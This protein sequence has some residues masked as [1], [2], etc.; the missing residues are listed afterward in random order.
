[1]RFALLMSAL[2]LAG[3]LTGALILSLGGLNIAWS[4]TKA[5][6][7]TS[8]TQDRL[9]AAASDTINFL[10]TNGNYAQTR[11]FPGA[12]INAPNVGKLRHAWIFQTEEHDVLAT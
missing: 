12:Q 1:M 6:P 2:K 10:H 4:Q 7:A 11:Y 5:A 3:T 8:V 9:N